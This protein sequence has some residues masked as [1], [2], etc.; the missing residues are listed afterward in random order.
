LTPGRA[1]AILWL[2]WL[3][4]WIAAAF[5]SAPTAR[6]PPWREEAFYRGLTIAGGFLLFA[7]SGRI[8]LFHLRLW[9]AGYEVDWLL[10]AIVLLGLLF[11]LWARL[12][13]GSLWS[14]S[15]TKKADHHIVDT[16]PYGIVR[17]PI[18]TG[19]IVAS[20]ATAVLEGTAAGLAGAVFITLGF[21]VK[22][23][24][25]ESFLGEHLGA[26]SYDSYRRR[27]PMLVPFAPH[28]SDAGT[29]TL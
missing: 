21:A 4:S 17:H 13:L 29:L 22:A 1:V 24:L 19:L 25:E 15:V 9:E 3:A 26:E 10:V 28:R 14:S 5:Q 2:A 8:R 7:G 27:V 23:R 6:R 16:G 20:F 11:T 12:Y 18:Y